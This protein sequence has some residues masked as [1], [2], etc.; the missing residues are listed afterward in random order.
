MTAY[1]LGF[2]LSLTAP[3]AVAIPLNWRPGAWRSVKSWLYKIPEKERPSNDDTRGQYERYIK[4]ADWAVD[5][6]REVRASVRYG[7]ENYAFSRNNAQ[8]SR[9]ME[10]GGI[11]RIQLYGAHA[12]IATVVSASS[13]RKLLLGKVPRSDQKLAVQ[14][15]LFNAAGAPKDWEENICDAFTVTNW[16]LTE[17]GGKALLLHDGTNSTEKRKR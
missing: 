13:A 4:I 7:I 10:L 6:A 16:M 2:D 3:A 1:A 15:A 11:V 14:Y 12:M 5:V 17:L 8:A 9:L